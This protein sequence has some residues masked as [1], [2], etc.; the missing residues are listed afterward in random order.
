MLTVSLELGTR[1]C[2]LFGL[3]NNLQ[4][5]LK[6]SAR[7]NKWLPDTQLERIG[8]TGPSANKGLLMESELL[9]RGLPCVNSWV[10]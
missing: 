3:I 9:I 6:N 1:F 5:H 10:R 4:Y 2:L 8:F 7:R